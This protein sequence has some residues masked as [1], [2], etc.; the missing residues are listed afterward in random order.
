MGPFIYEQKN[1]PLMAIIPLILAIFALLFFLFFSI[2]VLLKYRQARVEIDRIEQ[3][4]KAIKLP[5]RDKRLGG[6]FNIVEFPSTSIQFQYFRGELIKGG[7]YFT[8]LPGE[9]LREQLPGVPAREILI[10]K[11]SPRK[12]TRKAYKITD[13]SGILEEVM[14]YWEEGGSGGV[15]FNSFENVMVENEPERIRRF[16]NH[17]KELAEREGKVVLISLSPKALPAKYRRF[18]RDRLEVKKI[19]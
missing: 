6:A 13:L 10:V 1:S 9:R 15:V 18:L 2:R 12:Y 8:P 7:L 16:L 5:A 3:K 11:D 19:V 4:K 17:L 14:D